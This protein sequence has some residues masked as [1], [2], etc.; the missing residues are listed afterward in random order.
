MENDR[1]AAIVNDYDLW[2]TIDPDYDAL[3]ER[4]IFRL[5]EEISRVREEIARRHEEPIWVLE[6]GCG[7]GHTS[8][9]ILD[10]DP[11]I[12]L[13]AVDK[14]RGMVEKAEATLSDWRYR[15]RV[16]VWHGDMRDILPRL[17]KFHF[18]LSAFTFHNFPPAER[19]DVFRLA[20]SKLLPGG[21]FLNGDKIALDKK[22]EYLWTWQRV[23]KRLE[24]IKDT[25]PEAYAFW[26]KHEEDDDRIR[27]T[28]RGHRLHLK[29]AGLSEVVL[30]DRVG[31]NAVV[32]G[33]HP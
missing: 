30:T 26:K 8:R 14:S 4:L 6:I 18:V 5:K 23:L 27:L 10:A 21:L 3:H 19:A 2:R 7:T 16:N 29:K 11:R 33:K 1:F 20:A 24:I 15:E 31:M 13:S 12:R 9:L 25:H 32:Y 17:I 22:S 28:E